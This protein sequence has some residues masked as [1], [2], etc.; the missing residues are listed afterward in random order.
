M[1]YLEERA[2]RSAHAGRMEGVNAARQEEGGL[3]L[4]GHG[5]AQQRPE[6]AFLP[7]GASG[8]SM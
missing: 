3:P 1:W 8:S 2:L 6:E 5:G 4:E 7:A